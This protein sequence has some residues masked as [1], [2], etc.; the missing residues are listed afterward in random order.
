MQS[1]DNEQTA[2]DSL[3]RISSLV[4]DTDDPKI[5]LQSILDEIVKVLKP[6]S[7]SIL[8]VNPNSQDLDLEVTALK[9]H[10]F[11][12]ME[13]RSMILKMGGQYG[14]IGEV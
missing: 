14:V 11:S 12:S 2:I 9:I 3:Y 1:N 7:A 6:N 10:V 4:T 5:A 8:L 13:F